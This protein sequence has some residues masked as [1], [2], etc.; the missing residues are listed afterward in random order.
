VRRFARLGRIDRKAEEKVAAEYVRLLDIRTAGLWQKVLQL[1]GG[2]Q[3]K[4]VL[5]KW[6]A[7]RPRVLILD[8][9]TKGVDVGAKAAIHSIISQL[10]ADGLAILMISSELPEILGMSDRVLVMHEGSITAD[11]SRAEATQEKI[12]ASATGRTGGH[13]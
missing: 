6:L 10:A 1:S 12:L 9:P 8:E 7:T 13:A 3:Q 11:F 2:N 5:A 4:V